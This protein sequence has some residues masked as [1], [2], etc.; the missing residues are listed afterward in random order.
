ML[1]AN[2][3]GNTIVAIVITNRCLCKRLAEQFQ[4]RNGVGYDQLSTGVDA[5]AWL[6]RIS[7]VGS[8]SRGSVGSFLR[9]AEVKEAR[10]AFPRTPTPGAVATD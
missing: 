10:V 3:D 9:P 2:G 6:G 8:L 1:T 4:E 5:Y 7:H